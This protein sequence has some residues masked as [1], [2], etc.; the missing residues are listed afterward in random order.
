MQLNYHLHFFYIYLNKNTFMKILLPM[1]FI[2]TMMTAQVSNIVRH[3]DSY[4][5]FP[6][7]GVRIVQVD[8][9]NSPDSEDNVFIFSK[10]EKGAKPDKMTFQ[11]F[12]KIGGEWK[13]KAKKQIEHAGIISS[14]GQ[15]KSFADYDKDKSIDALFIYSLN[16]Y[17]FKQQSVH[18]IFSKNAEFY[19]ISTSAESGY[20]KDVY[21][22]NFKNLRQNIKNEILEYWNKLDKQ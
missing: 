14:W 15:R 16:D 19:E 8:E 11:R 2:G 9:V 5:D 3:Q 10:I 17:D 21:S 7:E 1:L 13:V 20:S 12:T 22:D 4:K 6:F 18:L